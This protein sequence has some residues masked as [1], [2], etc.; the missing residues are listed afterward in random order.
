MNQDAPFAGGCSCGGI[1]YEASGTPFSETLCHCADCRRAAGA[2]AVAW[3]TVRPAQFR[4]MGGQP[5]TFRSSPKVTRGFCPDCGTQLTFASDDLPDEIDVTTATLDEPDRL[6]P[7][8][9]CYAAS[10]VAWDHLSPR[11][12]VRAKSA[13]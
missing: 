9:H 11:I 10:R 13:T 12:P 6:P 4:I 3:F 7:K 5:K 8:D 2:P 1:R